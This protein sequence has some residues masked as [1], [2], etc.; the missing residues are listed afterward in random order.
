MN[1]NSI[2]QLIAEKVMRW[3]LRKL[4][5]VNA[6][7]DEKGDWTLKQM[8]KPATNIQD[9]WLVVEKLQA[10]FKSVE[11][12]LENGMTNVIVTENFPNGYLKDKYQGY[13]KNAALAI[14]KAALKAVGECSINEH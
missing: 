10:S 13:E 1:N 2:N 9:A 11:I 12:F 7:I 3:H 6:W 8:W 14:C 4:E 5:H